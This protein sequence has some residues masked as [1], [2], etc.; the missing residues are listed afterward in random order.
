[1]SVSTYDR[2]EDVIEN[3][4]VEGFLAHLACQLLARPGT[5]HGLAEALKTALV[6]SGASAVLKRV[7]GDYE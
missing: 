7:E 1:M 6:N 3:D 5:Q 4:H 2:A